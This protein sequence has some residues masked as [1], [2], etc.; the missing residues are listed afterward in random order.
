MV[1]QY[2]NLIIYLNSEEVK[3]EKNVCV[4]VCVFNLFFFSLSNLNNNIN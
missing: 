2:K 3:K 4:R 1:K